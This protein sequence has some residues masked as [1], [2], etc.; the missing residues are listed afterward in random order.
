MVLQ[1]DEVSGPD[2]ETFQEGHDDVTNVLRVSRREGEL[3]SL[4][5]GQTEA[6][7]VLFPRSVRGCVCVCVCLCVCVCVCVCVRFCVRVCHLEQDT[8][9]ISGNVNSNTTLFLSSS[10]YTPVWWW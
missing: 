10:A 5:G 4:D 3:L 1:S 8:A 2:L 7:S 6:L 9:V